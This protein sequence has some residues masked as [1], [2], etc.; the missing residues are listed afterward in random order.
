MLSCVFD[1]INNVANPKYKMLLT[2]T[3]NYEACEVH[4]LVSHPDK[5]NSQNYN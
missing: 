5:I 3:E 1:Q 2:P 4:S